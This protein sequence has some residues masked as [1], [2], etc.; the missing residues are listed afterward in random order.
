[1]KIVANFMNTR[2]ITCVDACVC[3]CVCVCVYTLSPLGVLFYLSFSKPLRPLKPPRGRYDAADTAVVR[4]PVKNGQD[5]TGPCRRSGR[6]VLQ[7][8]SVHGAKGVRFP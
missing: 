7:R 6:V 3:A 2:A 5:S 1:M 4:C 8:S